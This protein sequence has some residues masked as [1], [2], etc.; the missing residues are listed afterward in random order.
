MTHQLDETAADVARKYGLKAAEGLSGLLPILGPALVEAL[1][2]GLPPDRF[3]RVVEFLKAVD[4]RVRALDERMGGAERAQVVLE[5]VVASSL[6]A[7]RTIDPLKRARLA[8]VVARGIAADGVD[9]AYLRHVNDTVATLEDADVTILM[10]L[11]P[12]Y[13]SNPNWVEANK[14][15]LGQQVGMLGFGLGSSPDKPLADVVRARMIGS[16]LAVRTN[17]VQVIV[18]PDDRGHHVF[19]LVLAPAGVDVLLQLGLV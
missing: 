7:A 18:T 13:Q 9:Q 10:S 16:G 12:T 11:H 19:P 14:A 17:K 4:Q 5:T 3:E 6:T 2:E 15:L 8:E 1:S